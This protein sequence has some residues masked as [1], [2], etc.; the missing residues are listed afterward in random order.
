[1]SI[2]SKLL[3]NSKE[4]KEVLGISKSTAYRYLRQYPDFPKPIKLSQNKTLWNAPKIVEWL[5]NNF[6]AN[7]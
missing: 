1:M 7:N 5:E 6:Q 2:P 4:L 3:I